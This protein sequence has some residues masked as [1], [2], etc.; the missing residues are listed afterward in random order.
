MGFQEHSWNSV[1]FLG[2]LW[3]SVKVH[4]NFRKFHEISES[5]MDVLGI[6]WSSWEFHRV[7]W[8]S[9]EF[10]VNARKILCQWMQL[11]G[12]P[13][14][15]MGLQENSSHSAEFQGSPWNAMDIH[16]IW[17]ESMDL[18]GMPY[19]SMDGHW[20]FKEFHGNEIDFMQLHGILFIAMECNWIGSDEN[21]TQQGLWRKC[22]TPD[23]AITRKKE[24]ITG[25]CDH[26]KCNLEEM[27]SEKRWSKKKIMHSAPTIGNLCP[28]LSFTTW[29]FSSSCHVKPQC[30]GGLHLLASIFWHRSHPPLHTPWGG[31]GPGG[32]KTSQSLSKSHSVTPR[33]EGCAPP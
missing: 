3:N 4:G 24:A 19:T 18:N 22:V 25:N 2:N 21:I 33:G 29:R 26:T 10:P 30:Q 31:G 5:S 1:E 27:W 15:S 32:P 8:N 17:W 6:P 16:G 11:H 13:W 12:I 14:N 7:P 23:N 28:F 9:M 20:N